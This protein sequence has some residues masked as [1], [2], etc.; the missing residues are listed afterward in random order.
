VAK[1][2]VWVVHFSDGEGHEQEGARPA[3]IMGDSPHFQMAAVIP[4]TSQKTS[5]RF[6]FTYS[7][8][9]SKLNGLEVDSVFLVPQ[10]RSVSKTR[11]LRK[12]GVLEDK[13]LKQLDS[14]VRDLLKL[15]AGSSS[16]P[17]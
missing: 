14:L 15:D 1:G 7:V 8:N 13:D 3:V 17:I 6:P 4:A 5:T 10:I 9:S 11:L 16:Q 12:M 2:E